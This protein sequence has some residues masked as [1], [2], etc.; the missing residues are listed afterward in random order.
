MGAPFQSPQLDVGQCQTPHA[1]RGMRAISLYSTLRE[2]S[3]PLSTATLTWHVIKTTL[4]V[5]FNPARNIHVERKYFRD[6]AR[7]TTESFNEYALPLWQL[8]T[9]C[10]YGSFLD[11]TLSK[12]FLQGLNQP[13]VQAKILSETGNFNALVSAAYR[14][15]AEIRCA[16]NTTP[17]TSI[18]NIHK[19]KDTRHNKGQKKG[20]F[21]QK[22]NSPSVF[23]YKLSCKGRE[24]IALLRMW[25][26]T[27]PKGLS[28]HEFSMQ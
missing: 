28:I 19:G 23:E 12:Q 25:G 17:T 15:Q 1:S 26:R 18:N 27:L 4:S 7:K 8:A 13:D 3:K 16:S 22:K 21:N 14:I 2:L 5:H 10:N 20:K 24:E 9:T 11:H 6:R